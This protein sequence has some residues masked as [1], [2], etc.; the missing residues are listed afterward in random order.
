[1]PDYL[2]RCEQHGPFEVRRPMSESEQ[3]GWCPTCGAQCERD[4][5]AEFRSQVMGTDT[6]WHTN[7]SDILHPKAIGA[8]PFSEDKRRY[9]PDCGAV[10]V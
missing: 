8:A 7:W 10:W 6:G 9:G 2:Y 4:R 1:M 3:P 5:N